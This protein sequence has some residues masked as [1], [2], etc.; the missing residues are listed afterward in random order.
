VKARHWGSFALLGVVD[1][2]R[3]CRPRSLDAKGCN[4][5]AVLQAGTTPPLGNGCE[6]E[7]EVSLAVPRGGAQ[8]RGR[9]SCSPPEVN[10]PAT[11]RWRRSSCAA[12]VPSSLGCL[13][14]EQ[15]GACSSDHNPPRAPACIRRSI[16]LRR[17]ASLPDQP[18][19]RRCPCRRTC[20]W[21]LRSGS[22]SQTKRS[23]VTFK[24]ARDSAARRRF[25][26]NPASRLDWA[27]FRE[28]TPLKSLSLLP[29]HLK[30]GALGG[31]YSQA[32]CCPGLV[33]GGGSCPS[34]LV[35]SCAVA[36]PR[37]RQCR[38]RPCALPTDFR[39]RSASR[40][41]GLWAFT[42]PP[43]KACL[44]YTEDHASGGVRGRQPWQHDWVGSRCGGLRRM[45]HAFL[46]LRH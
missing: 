13:P 8:C 26:I 34:T 38:Y 35:P 24:A 25:G 37:P 12:L 10:H 11:R 45:A 15:V 44:A 33:I 9:P 2:C 28:G 29:D 42:L 1:T 20:C 46:R 19:V 22:A 31:A 40:R 27:A 6:K 3:L 17:S 4:V 36:P 7:C 21:L 5:R 14:G 16:A 41:E 43:L 18:F 39:S 23:S 32:R 30:R